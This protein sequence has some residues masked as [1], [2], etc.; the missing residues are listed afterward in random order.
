M[1]KKKH[2]ILKL[3]NVF[4]KCEN[5]E[6]KAH[7]YFIIYKIKIHTTEKRGKNHVVIM[8]PGRV[9]VLLCDVKSPN[10]KP[11]LLWIVTTDT[12]V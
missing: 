1:K 6:K 11:C 9:T 7:V 4:D 8:V 3:Y 5:R 12:I 10:T 2:E